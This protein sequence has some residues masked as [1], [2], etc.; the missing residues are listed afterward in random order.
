MAEAD[1]L[2]P[3]A[4]GHLVLCYIHQMNRVNSRSGSAMMT[5]P[6]TS[7]L[8]VYCYYYLSLTQAVDGALLAGDGG[9]GGSDEGSTLTLSLMSVLGQRGVTIISVIL[10]ASL[11]IILAFL[12]AAICL[13]RRRRHRYLKVQTDVTLLSLLRIAW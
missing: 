9:S 1:Q 10:L 6:Q 12:V 3:K 4:G 13:I 8:L 5:A 11:V 2:G 7:A